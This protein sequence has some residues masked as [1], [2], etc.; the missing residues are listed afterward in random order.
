M[1]YKNYFRRDLSDIAEFS[2]GTTLLASY[3]FSCTVFYFTCIRFRIFSIFLISIVP[4]LFQSTNADN[5][6]GVFLVI[7]LV[8]FFMLYV[9]KTRRDSTYGHKEGFFQINKWYLSAAAI[10][11][12]IPVFFSILLPKPN[13]RPKL[14]DL[15][16]I[17]SQA[18]DTGSLA[19]Q[20]IIQNNE[21]LELV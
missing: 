21:L 17:I 16:R 13:T 3:F 9:D 2:Y 10:F 18:I 19:V 20:N 11:V 12:L 1:V 6:V 5:S 8:L 7:F 15:D 4:L 14:A